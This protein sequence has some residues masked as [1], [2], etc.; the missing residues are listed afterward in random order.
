LTGHEEVFEMESEPKG[1]VD[2]LPKNGIL[3]PNETVHVICKSK[4][5]SKAAIYVN[6]HN[7]LES[8]VKNSLNLKISLLLSLLI[9]CFIYKLWK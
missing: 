9:I 6:H 3:S 2:F 7:P 1:A 4:C 5:D 8:R